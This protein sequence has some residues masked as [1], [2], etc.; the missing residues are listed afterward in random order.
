ME[1]EEERGGQMR[2]HAVWILSMGLVISPIAEAENKLFITDVLDPGQMEAQGTLRFTRSS[3]VSFTASSGLTGS[4]YRR[5]SRAT[6]SLGRGISDGFQLDAAIPYVFTDD[7]IDTFSG[8]TTTRDRSGIGDLDLGL[9]YRI[10]GAER[11]PSVVSARLD[12]KPETA[13][14]KKAGTGATNISPQLAASLR[15]G[16]S[17]RPYGVYQATFR[18]HGQADTHTLTVGV[19]KTFSETVVVTVETEVS[20]NTASDINASYNRY[21]I[22]L[23]SYVQIE[24][25]LYLIPALG[26]SWFGEQRAI[27]GLSRVDSQTVSAVSLGIYYL[28]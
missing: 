14:S 18:N 5:T 4:G 22:A 24:R 20:I 11:G 21:G 19:E 1:E 3:N 2:N 15:I 26:F 23:S 17:L 6:V 10:A 28:F 25:N 7:Q 27:S 13:D 8:I 12:I 16:D 9:K